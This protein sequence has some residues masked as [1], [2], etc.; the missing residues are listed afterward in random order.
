MSDLREVRLVAFPLRVHQRATEHHEELMR[1][2]QLLAIAESNGDA[3]PARLVS[4]IAELTTSYSGVASAAD[5]ERDAAL[6]RG[7][8]TLD[9][10]YRVPPE[11]AEA[12]RRL[13]RMLDEADAFCRAEQL[14]T[15]EAPPEAVAFRRWYLREF[16]AQL[17]GAEPTPWPAVAPSVV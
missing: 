13:E 16:P 5:A 12:C 1:E 11:A 6:A 3:V 15:L 10:V 4:L 9:L 2:F 14:L 8:D 17:A 7:E